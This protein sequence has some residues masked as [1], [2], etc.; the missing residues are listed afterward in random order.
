MDTNDSQQCTQATQSTAPPKK[1]TTKKTDAE[2]EED[3]KRKEKER[4]LKKAEKLE[5]KDV[6]R[7]KKKD[8]A[9]M[10]LTA[11]IDARFFTQQPDNGEK[12]EVNLRHGG[13]KIEK[14]ESK[15]P[16]SIFWG[17]ESNNAIFAPDFESS[18]PST[19]TSTSIK[20]KR[21]ETPVT[22]SFLKNPTDHFPTYSRTEPFLYV[23]ISA[24]DVCDKIA[25]GTFVQ[26][27]EEIQKDHHDK[28]LTVLIEG[29]DA[30][31]SKTN[32]SN[33]TKA[34]READALL[35]QASSSSSQPSRKK[36]KSTE[37][38]FLPERQLVDS[39]L[40]EVQLVNQCQIIHSQK[41]EDTHEYI[42]RLTAII[43]HAPY[44]RTKPNFDFCP[45]SV[46]KSKTNDMKQVWA[47]Q[48]IQIHGVT[49]SIATS[50]TSQYPTFHSLM[51]YYTNP[52]LDEHTKENILAGI[53][54][55]NKTVGTALSSKIYRIFTETDQ[56]RIL[57]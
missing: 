48:L 31:W 3:K 46:K 8:E 49:D 2:K 43:A 21:Q 29:L 17:R 57:H 32:R 45:E 28:K 7:T 20:R 44:R 12:M 11:Y 41:Q 14:I 55:G 54:V 5:E 4:E 1:K 26:H 25:S 35:S 42:G 53:I 19:S 39:T 52:I 24:Q 40:V 33:S 37:L 47:N 13:L 34:Q 56:K 6:H 18:P 16:Y 51:Q 9:V 15:T 10:E 27:I 50:I 22:Q 36:G 23:Q 30:Y 38:V